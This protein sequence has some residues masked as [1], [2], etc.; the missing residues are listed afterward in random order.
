LGAGEDIY[1]TV[2]KVSATLTAD[3]DLETVLATVARQVGEAMHATSCDITDYDAVAQTLTFAGEWTLEM[4]PQDEAYVGTVIP[5]AGRPAR[6]SVVCEREV[7]EY[8]LDDPGLD[9]IEREMM[10]KW[11]ES[12]AL[13]VPLV[14]ADEVIGILGVV[15]VDRQRRYSDSDKA[16]L[17]ALAVP[18]AAAINNARTFAASRERRRLH[19][20]ARRDTRCGDARGRPARGVPRVPD[21]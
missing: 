1:E 3:L 15:D 16:L 18:A 2:F 13:D 12:T 7:L 21:L 19:L 14:F 11:D 20:R 4:S 6:L 8:Y 5:L 17:Q 9:P 10:E